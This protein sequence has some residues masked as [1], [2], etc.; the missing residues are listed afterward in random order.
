MTTLHSKS[1]SRLRKSKNRNNTLQTHRQLK[2]RQGYYLYQL[3]QRCNQRTPIAAIELK[4]HWLIQAGFNIDSPVKVRVMTGC[5]VLT[6][7]A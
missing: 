7:Q 4:G 3:A 5:L 6:V 2:V 1:G